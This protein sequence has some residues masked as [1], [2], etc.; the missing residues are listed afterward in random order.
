VGKCCRLF[1]FIL[2]VLFCLSFYLS[3]LRFFMGLRQPLLHYFFL[4]FFLCCRWDLLLFS[5]TTY[6]RLLVCTFVRGFWHVAEAFCKSTSGLDF[7]PP[8]A[9]SVSYSTTWSSLS[10]S[11]N[12]FPNRLGWPV[13]YFWAT[14]YIYQKKIV[15][16]Q[17]K[18]IRIEIMSH[19]T[20]VLY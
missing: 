16:H 4:W 15:R 11:S 8:I 17:K 2:L 6:V 20:S 13:G 12:N 3:Y 10:P 18:L 5:T 9:D 19:R 7:L 1:H 14:F